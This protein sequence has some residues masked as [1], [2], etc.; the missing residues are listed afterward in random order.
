MEVISQY[1]VD[2]PVEWVRSFLLIGITDDNLTIAGDVVEIRQHDRLLDLVVR[3]T[4]TAD[5]RG[6]TLLDVEAQLRLRGLARIV[7]AVFPRRVRR[8]LVRSLDGLPM[9]IE[10]SLE[11]EDAAASGRGFAEESDPPP[12]DDAMTGQRQEAEETT[13]N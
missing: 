11:E 10:Q 12:G 4:V 6:G 3:N 8:T 5:Q 9:A 7:G 2:A 13:G 1:R